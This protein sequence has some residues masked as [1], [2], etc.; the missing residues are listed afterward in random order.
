MEQET[1]HEEWK[2][3]QK[4]SSK[5]T[6]EVVSFT[7]PSS[8]PTST[9]QVVTQPDAPTWLKLNLEKG[10]QVQSQPITWDEMVKEV[11]RVK[12]KKKPHVVHSTRLTD[13]VDLIVDI[14]T[15]VANKDDRE[16]QDT[17]Y[18]INTINL[19]KQT[20]NQQ[21]NPIDIVATTTKS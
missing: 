18:Q 14:A 16:L 5:Q 15:P 11:D 9:Q 12:P 21:I 10:Q 2:E 13:D 8:T 20:R 6:T 19:G 4:T 3:Q 17:Y 7:P 1:L